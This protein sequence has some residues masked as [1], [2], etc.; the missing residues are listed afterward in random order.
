MNNKFSIQDLKNSLFEG[1][2]L[3]IMKQFPDE[4]IDMVLCD[5]PYGTTQNKWD[6][7]IDFDLL[8]KEI[9]EL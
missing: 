3:E 2:C 7:I 6:E 5:L 9:I 8:W 1:N 4:S